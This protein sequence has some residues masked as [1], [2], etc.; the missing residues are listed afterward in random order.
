M[1]E[2]I[3]KSN[4]SEKLS[5]A[6]DPK[7]ELRLQKGLTLPHAR[8]KPKRGDK[9]VLADM[10]LLALL[11]DAT[12]EADRPRRREPAR[13][14]GMTAEQR[15]AARER[16]LAVLERNRKP[17][18]LRSRAHLL[19]LMEPGAAYV[20][21]DLIRACPQ[22]SGD[23]VK[24]HLRCRMLQQGLVERVPAPPGMKHRA[25]LMHGARH[26]DPIRWLYR[27]TESGIAERAA[28][29]DGDAGES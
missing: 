9:D 24:G 15:A 13:Q 21:N 18:H 6:K 10:G 25:P 5:L 12:P 7:K 23:A 19:R 20:V 28:V 22:L 4:G 1:P 11:P 14:L 8:V 3:R 29:Q 17:A 27:L 26:K 2:R 16:I